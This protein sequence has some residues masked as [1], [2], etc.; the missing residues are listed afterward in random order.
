MFGIGLISL[1]QVWFLPGL[2]LLAFSKK[3]KTIDKLLLSLPLS[4]TVN[5]IIIFFLV[6]LKSYNQI[7][8]FIL[9]F[10]EFSIIFFFL[11]NKIDKKKNGIKELLNFIEFKKF[12]FNIDFID[13]II[14]VI[15]LVYLFLAITNIGNVISVGDSI[16]YYNWTLDII[17]NKIPQKSY[18]YPPGVAILNSISFVLLN[19]LEIEFFTASIFLIQPF[20]FFLI[21]YRIVFFFKKFRRVIKFSL[22][23]VS[24]IVLYNFRHYLLYVNL[25][26][27]TVA[28]SS[29]IG[30][31]VLIL[32]RKYIIIGLNIET[33]LFCL[34]MAYSSILKQVGVYT[35]ILYPIMYFIFFYK[36]DKKI[37]KNFVLISVVI[38][39][40]ISPWY[41]FKLYHSLIYGFA[42][43]SI[44]SIAVSYNNYDNIFIHIIN[45]FQ[46][47]FLGYGYFFILLL[48]FISLQNKIAQKI[49][50]VFTLPFFL[51]YALLFGYEFRAFAPAM[52]SIGILC[53][54]G[55][56]IL[57]DFLKII[58]S[59]KKILFIYRLILGFSFIF[60]VF[61]INELRDFEKLKYLNTQEKKKRGDYELNVL[62][63]N[64]LTAEDKVKIVYVI[65]DF[66]NLNLLPEINHEFLSLTCFDFEKI[67]KENINRSFYILI[68]KREVNSI[69]QIKFC[70]EIFINTIEN[71]NEKENVQKV[72]EY[73]NYIMYLR[74]Y[75]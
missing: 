5:Y 27:A 52:G 20:W 64:F 42:D 16:T 31:Y 51:A 69:N 49:F 10:V 48:I 23:F 15:F 66:N 75:K 56:N 65:R 6:L 53:G 47:L 14:I 25:P 54:I 67:Y 55:L 12:K 26:D 17:N 36:K 22:I 35:S 33:I 70:N 21:S 68:D 43:T 50:F 44:Y 9:I 58:F 24:I 7:S 3:L 18:D 41:L 1:L 13:V 11:K 45:I 63:Y 8:L 30:A 19:T 32:C 40:I 34:V 4:V 74:K 39:F 62:L 38:F 57:I 73:K 46:R 28:L 71:I 59:K 37:F 2:C 61:F 60:F 29:I 72:F